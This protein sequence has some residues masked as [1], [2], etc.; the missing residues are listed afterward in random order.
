MPINHRQIEG[1]RA[2]VQAGSMTN[3]AD[4]L[5]ISQPAVSRLIRDLEASLKLRLFRREGNR[6]VPTQEGLVLFEEV[7]IHYRGI[8]QIEKVAED[9]RTSSAGNI[10]VAGSSSLSTF[11]LPSVTAEFLQE[12]PSVTVSI[13]NLHSSVILERIALQQFDIGLVQIAGDYP[14]V[15]IMHLPA[16]PA[17]CIVPRDHEL[18]QHTVLTPELLAGQRFISLGQNSPLRRRIDEV[19]ARRDLRRLQCAEASLAASV[20][21]LVARGVGVAIVDPFVATALADESDVVVRPFLPE[22]PFEVA[23]ITPMHRDL[24]KHARQFL[25]LLSRRFKDQRFANVHRLTCSL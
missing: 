10:R 5:G 4:L 22:I 24:S 19:F 21:A 7:D 2:V 17:V 20:R 9:L 14:G 3:A 25:N 11:F 8:A 6:L 23:L 1:F 12:H 15:Q 18:S 16:A 13:N